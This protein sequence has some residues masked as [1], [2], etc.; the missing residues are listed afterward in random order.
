MR[1]R[2]ALAALA[3]AMLS[4][5]AAA[6]PGGPGSAPEPA[7]LWMGAIPG[8]TPSTL[9]G[10]AVIDTSAAAAI[11]DRGGAVFLDV[12]E[13]DRKPPTLPATALWRPQHRSIP[14]A[15]WLPGAATGD[16]PASQEQA[17]K[18][19]VEALTGGDMRRPVV[20]F[21][22][23]DCWGSWNMGKRLVTWGYLNV[24]WFPDG[25]EGWQQ[26]DRD[27]GVVKADPDW[28]AATQPEAGR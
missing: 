7:G 2:F 21:C 3:V 12:A 24:S 4:G 6:A 15:V 22:H 28:V 18:T 10:A 9:K 13:A 23:P 11:F 17:L 8:Y 27:T 20:A 19:R 16:L 1:R 14:G 5:V 25:V 26:A